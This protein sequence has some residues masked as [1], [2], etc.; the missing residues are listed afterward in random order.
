MS[1]ETTKDVN[2]RITYAYQEIKT[3]N[4]THDRNKEITKA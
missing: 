4:M 3:S 2:K 1:H